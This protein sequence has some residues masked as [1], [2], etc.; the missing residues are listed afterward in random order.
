MAK[1]KASK[2]SQAGKHR[3]HSRPTDRGKKGGK[4]RDGTIGGPW[5]PS[6]AQLEMYRDYV[7]AVPTGEIAK[8]HDLT[9][10]AININVRKVTQWLWQETFDDIRSVKAV[11]VS[12]FMMIYRESIE[13]WE[14]SKGGKKTETVNELLDK[15]EKARTKKK[16][17]KQHDLEIRRTTKHDYSA[18]D[19]RYLEVAIKALDEICRIM[20]AYAPVEI[21]HSGEMR[22]AGMP[23]EEAVQQRRDYY[24]KLLTGHRN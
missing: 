23:I 6:V 13:A 8:Q 1:K 22:V 20:G 5:E 15:L 10:R 16:K 11:Q 18:G 24:D 7:N 19:A 4:V 17:A 3:R 9:I 12:R 21:K 2:K 14:K